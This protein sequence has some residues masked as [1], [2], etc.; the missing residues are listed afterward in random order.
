MLIATGK[1]VYHLPPDVSSAPP[2]LL[3]E[4][5]SVQAL[6]Q[7]GLLEA[8]AAGDGRIECW[9][10]ADKHFSVETDIQD[11]IT[12]MLVLD[13]DTPVLLVGTEPPHIYRLEGTIA[14]P[15]RNVSFDHL[16]CRK[17]WF[18]PWGGPPAVRSLARGGHNHVYADIHVGSIIRSADTGESW[19]PVTPTLHKDVHQVNTTPA[20]SERVYANTADAVWVSFDYGDSWAPRPFPHDVSYGRAIAIHPKDPDCL[21]ATASEGPHGHDVKG[22]LYRSDDTG[23]NWTHVSQGFPPYTRDNINT[24][25]VVF[26]QYGVAWA[27]VKNRLFKSNDRGKSWTT[28]WKA[29]SP[30]QMLSTD[31][32]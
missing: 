10:A 21:L 17:D 4:L 11:T 18:T 3:A 19:T 14:P 25:H 1:R 20:A 30:I 9:L 24:H 26:D 28:F 5:D 22:R 15:V 32:L 23:R 2:E 13:P 29:P 27:T 16:D 8:A 31:L 7:S 6:V 12:S